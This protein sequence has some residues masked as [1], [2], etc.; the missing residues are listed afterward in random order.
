ME[1]EREGSSKQ[2]IDL[3]KAK[4]DMLIKQKLE[5]K[6]KNKGGNYRRKRRSMLDMIE[7][8]DYDDNNNEEQERDAPIREQRIRNKND[9][10]L[11]KDER[12]KE[13]KRGKDRYI[14]VINNIKR[15][16]I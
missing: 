9:E 15:N 6:S 16:K 2:R 5:K 11:I 10:L 4:V 1:S 3:V 13:I 7:Y 14:S 12:S 8:Y